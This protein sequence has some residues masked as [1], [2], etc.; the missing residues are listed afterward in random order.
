MNINQ[1]SQGVKPNEACRDHSQQIG[2]DSLASESD[3]R[4]QALG[5][6]LSHQSGTSSIG[7]AGGGE[8]ASQNSE[9]DKDDEEEDYH[10]PYHHETKPKRP[11]TCYN[12]F[13]RCERKRILAKMA[14]EISDGSRP[15]IDF[16]KLGSMISA[17]WKETPQEERKKYRSMAAH[18][19]QRYERQMEEWRDYMGTVIDEMVDNSNPATTATTAQHDAAEEGMETGET[20]SKMPAP[21]MLPPSGLQ[22]TMASGNPHRPLH[23]DS[24][25]MYQRSPT[26][27]S[28][29]VQQQQQ[30][31]HQ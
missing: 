14:E 16:E 19:R 27:S 9:Q 3:R 24:T 8:D 23:H 15:K 29:S 10:K 4:A 18:D 2:M 6:P 25:T 12:M 21:R 20:D 11:L 7:L 5:S 1:G 22:N 30:Q 26:A 31:Q 28:S 17:R 13:F